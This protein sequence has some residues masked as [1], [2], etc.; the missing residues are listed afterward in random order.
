M[1]IISVLYY[2]R[3]SKEI[4]PKTILYLVCS[5][6]SHRKKISKENNEL[7]CYLN[8]SSYQDASKCYYNAILIVIIVNVNYPN[9]LFMLVS[10]NRD[11]KEQARVKFAFFPKQGHSE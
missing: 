11:S 10:G 5:N 4:T 6:Q 9:Q 8:T 2:A 1:T 3:M 7:I